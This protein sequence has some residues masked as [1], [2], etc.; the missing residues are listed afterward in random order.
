MTSIVSGTPR[1]TISFGSEAYSRDENGGKAMSRALYWTTEGDVD[2]KAVVEGALAR[3]R[4]RKVALRVDG[5]AYTTPKSDEAFMLGRGKIYTQVKSTPQSLKR[6]PK[7]FSIR[8]VT[9][10]RQ[11]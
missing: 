5:N 10:A 2:R 9:V 4:K 6:L 11:F 7:G 3:R 1:T 8:A